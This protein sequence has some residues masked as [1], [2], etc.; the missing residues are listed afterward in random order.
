MK[1]IFYIVLFL[2]LVA[3]VAAFLD[4]RK[5]IKNSWRIPEKTL[6]FLAAIGGSIGLYIGMKTFRHKT[7]KLRFSIGIPLIIILQIIAIVYL[8]QYFNVELTSLSL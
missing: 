8:L 6:F 7:K 5:A 2:N 3:F 4:K 1:Y